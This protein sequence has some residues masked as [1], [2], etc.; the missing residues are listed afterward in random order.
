MITLPDV[1][2]PE[3]AGQLWLTVRVEQPHATAWSDARAHHAW[4]QWKLQEKL[5]LTQLPSAHT[6]PQLNVSENVFT[7]ENDNK[8]WQFDRQS[9]LL[10]QYWI[11]DSANC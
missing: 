7:V 9:G 11:G 1:P 8:R 6:A 4:Q 10:T 2:M 5:S 3:T